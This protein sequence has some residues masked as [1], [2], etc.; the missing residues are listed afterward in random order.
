[1]HIPGLKQDLQSSPA[2]PSDENHLLQTPT[3]G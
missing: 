2:V 3:V 1:M